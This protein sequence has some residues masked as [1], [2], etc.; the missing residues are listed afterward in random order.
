[1]FTASAT[2]N[3]RFVGMIA[4]VHV[5][6]YWRQ[7]R[8]KSSVAAHATRKRQVKTSESSSS[9]LIIW[10]NISKRVSSLLR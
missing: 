3:A 7:Q 8:R 2:R 10:T 1:M 5:L 4:T 6:G 9:G